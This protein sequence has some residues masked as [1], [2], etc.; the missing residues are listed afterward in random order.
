[1]QRSGTPLTG[2]VLV[3][4]GATFFVLN[5]GVSRV[6]QRAGVDSMTLTTVRCTGTAVMLLLVVA[7]LRLGYARPRGWRDLAR[8]L[9]FGITGVALVQWFYFVAIDHLPVGI[10]LLLEFTAP[11]LV[12]VFARVV[13]R[14]PV[15]RRLWLGLGLSLGG[16]AMVA[17]VWDGMTLDVVGVMAGLAAA[18]SLAT[19]FLVG[20]RSVTQQ[21]PVVVLTEAF[22]VAAIFWNLL[23]PVTHLG[24]ADLGADQSLGGT[25]AGAEAPLWTLLAFMVLLGTVVP[26]LAELSALRYLSA[27][28]VALVG[29]LEPVGA[30]V[31]GWLWF[32]ESLL[33]AQIVG[34]VLVLT[35]IALAQTARRA[36][37][38]PAAPPLAT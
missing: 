10:A 9:G 11:I 30:G 14:E 5:A 27:T 4:V 21:A 35:G 12:A 38:A 8:I 3:L 34:V 26:F 15:R 33:A 1:M 28:E 31:L 16:L 7:A 2:L 37:A 24:D 22:V 13:Y 32:R 25:L 23:R 20:E 18:V 36:G 29:M 19:Y 17:Q 6:I